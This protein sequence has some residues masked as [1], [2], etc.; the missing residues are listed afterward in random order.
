MAYFGLTKGHPKVNLN[1]AVE[2]ANLEN[3][4]Q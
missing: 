4:S 2:L 3:H 1:D